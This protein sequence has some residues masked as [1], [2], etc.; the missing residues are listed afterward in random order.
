MAK[1]PGVVDKVGQRVVELS[2]QQKLTVIQASQFVHATQ[3]YLIYTLTS[4]LA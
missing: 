3:F 1:P 2:A 4:S